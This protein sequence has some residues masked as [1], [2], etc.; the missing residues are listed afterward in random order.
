[1]PRTDDLHGIQ[2][3][4]SSFGGNQSVE[5]DRRRCEARHRLDRSHEKKRETQTDY[6]EGIEEGFGYAKIMNT[7]A[8]QSLERNVYV[9]HASCEARVTPDIAVAH[10]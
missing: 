4:R 5:E 1:M 9:R 6:I 8:N 3:P 7:E 2:V 10:L